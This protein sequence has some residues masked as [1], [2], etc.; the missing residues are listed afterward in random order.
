MRLRRMQ[1]YVVTAEVIAHS[2]INYRRDL[3]ATIT[4]RPCLMMNFEED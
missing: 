4:G 3:G 2:E 1:P